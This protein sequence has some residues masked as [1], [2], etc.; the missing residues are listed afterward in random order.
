[1]VKRYNFI[2]SEPAFLMKSLTITF[3]TMLKI[4]VVLAGLLRAASPYIPDGRQGL[5]CVP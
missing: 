1:M 4:H 3:V 5:S 2:A